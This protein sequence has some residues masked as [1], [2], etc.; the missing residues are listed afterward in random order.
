MSPIYTILRVS[1]ELFNP[2]L[3]ILAVFI[4]KEIINYI[5]N[6][7]VA[8]DSSYIYKLLILMGLVALIKVIMIKVQIYTRIVH[9]EQLDQWMVRNMMDFL[10]M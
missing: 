4:S 8:Y 5:S 6:F 2:I 7:T 10:L 3:N 9:S 1:S